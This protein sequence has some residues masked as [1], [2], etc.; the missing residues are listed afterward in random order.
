MTKEYKVVTTETFTVTYLV[1]AEN[2]EQ[3][4]EKVENADYEW[5]I[6]NTPEEMSVLSTKEVTK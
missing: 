1:K 2:E 6:A 5:E 3:A 4:E